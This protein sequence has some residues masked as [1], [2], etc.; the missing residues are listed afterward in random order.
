MAGGIVIVV[1]LVLFPALVAM[2]GAVLA[3]TMGWALN[4]DRNA[5]FEGTEYLALSKANPY[6]TDD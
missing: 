6:A 2:G 4:R 5:A 3:A 1:V